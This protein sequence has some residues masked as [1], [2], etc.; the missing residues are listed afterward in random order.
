M[1]TIVKR[2]I[3]VEK[4]FVIIR[5]FCIKVYVEIA[6]H[7]WFFWYPSLFYNWILI[8]WGFRHLFI[9]YCTVVPFEQV[10]KNDIISVGATIK[11]YKNIIGCLKR[12]HFFN[13][14]YYFCWYFF[15]FINW[16]EQLY[17]IQLYYK[18][19]R[20]SFHNSKI[21]KDLFRRYRIKFFSCWCIE[22][23]CVI[24]TQRK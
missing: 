21:F 17:I 13:Y 6:L 7:Y 10:S 1:T 15:T 8:I 9:K 24:K 14:Y 22:I 5:N 12:H 18:T 4:V 16:S 3:N 2:E 19:K 23:G 11:R 20:T